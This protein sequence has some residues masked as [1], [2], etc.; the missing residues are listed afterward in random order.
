M[1]F[2]INNKLAEFNVNVYYD[3]CKT[4][5]GKIYQF[6]CIHLPALDNAYTCT[7]ICCVPGHMKYLLVNIHTWVS[8]MNSANNE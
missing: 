4:D 8:Y 3:S 2:I 7:C 5:I 6:M 1:P